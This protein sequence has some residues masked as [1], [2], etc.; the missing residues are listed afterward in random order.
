MARVNI[1]AVRIV[2]CTLSHDLRWTWQWEIS[3]FIARYAAFRQSW[4]RRMRK[5]LYVRLQ[6][7]GSPSW[8]RNRWFLRSARHSEFRPWL[9]ATRMSMAQAN[10]FPIRIPA[11]FQFS[12]PES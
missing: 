8:H 3:L 7:M 1:Y 2:M 4:N 11:S 5:L 9:F 6:Y 12:R 10:R